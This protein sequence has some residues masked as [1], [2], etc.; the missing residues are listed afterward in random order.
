VTRPWS[1]YAGWIVTA[2]WPGVAVLVARWSLVPGLVLYAMWLWSVLAVG[3]KPDKAPA[4]RAKVKWVQPSP[5]W[6]Q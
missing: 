3:R 4:P 1:W 5:L 2:G 6:W